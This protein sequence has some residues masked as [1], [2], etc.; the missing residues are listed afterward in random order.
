MGRAMAA[1]LAEHEA[2]VGYLREAAGRH[3]P[4]LIFALTFPGT[5]PL[6]ELPEFRQVLTD[7]RLPAWV[8][9]A[10]RATV[11]VGSSR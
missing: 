8:G 4:F 11:D 10:R 1:A 2:A 9:R 5:D 6:R 3:D 7:I